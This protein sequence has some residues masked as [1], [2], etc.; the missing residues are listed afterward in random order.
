MDKWVILLDFCSIFFIKLG[1]HT[2]SH[3]SLRPT[4]LACCPSTWDL[5]DQRARSTW[6]S[7]DQ[8]AR[9][10]ILVNIEEHSK[11]AC[12]KILK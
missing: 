9:G 3:S 2:T 7:K 8:R 4:T 11:N 12:L 10:T 6:Y 5:K 1:L